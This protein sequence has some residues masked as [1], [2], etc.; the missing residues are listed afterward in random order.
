MK[1]RLELSGLRHP[2]RSAH[3]DFVSED[4]GRGPMNAILGAVNAINK[5]RAASANIV[6]RII[7]DGLD[8]SGLDLCMMLAA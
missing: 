2:K 6:Y 8:A 3:S 4:L 1:Q 7:N 5:E